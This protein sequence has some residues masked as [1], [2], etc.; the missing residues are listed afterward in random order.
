MRE[1]IVPQRSIFDQAIDLLISIFKPS[2][3]LKNM[4]IVIDANPNM[5]KAVHADES[6][7]L[8]QY[9]FHFGV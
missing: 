3:K 9:T 7:E 6:F 2:R 1:R 8:I 5:V 4:D